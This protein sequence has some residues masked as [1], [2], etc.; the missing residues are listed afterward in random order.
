MEIKSNQTED[1]SAV[2]ALSLDDLDGV[3]G[4]SA[5]RTGGVTYKR[6]ENCPVCGTKLV[7][8]RNSTETE[9][10]KC[11]TVVEAE[12]SSGNPFYQG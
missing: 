8:T 12:Q 5:K 1:R 11:Y 10:M 4:G 2:E 7:W 6:A 3:S 9:C